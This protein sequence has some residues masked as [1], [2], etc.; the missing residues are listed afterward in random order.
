MKATT[1]IQIAGGLHLGLLWA[2]ATMPKSVRLS[3]HLA[4]LPP[5]VRRLFWVYWTFVGLVLLGMGTITFLYAPVL[6][7]GE[8]LA[9]ALSTFLALFWTLRLA[10]AAFVFDV[11]RYLTCWYYR[12]GYHGTTATF[13]YLTA[14]YTWLAFR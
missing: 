6:A 2:G 9:R 12:L 1:L 3:H 14:L 10:V 11:R 7:A 4:G 5:F 8:P 13:I